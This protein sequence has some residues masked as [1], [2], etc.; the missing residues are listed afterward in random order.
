MTRGRCSSL[1]LH[2]DG[3]APSTFRR[4]PG[5]PV[6]HIKPGPK[7]GLRS[8]WL[9]KGLNAS[10]RHESAAA[11]I[12][13]NAPD[14]VR[15]KVYCRGACFKVTPSTVLGAPHGAYAGSRTVKTE[16]LARLACHGYV[17]ECSSFRRGTDMVRETSCAILFA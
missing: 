8:L 2:R 6:H 17:V 7:G 16:H 5:A 10:S 14:A 4:S 13:A 1:R 15:Q 12:G 3:L 11:D 9:W